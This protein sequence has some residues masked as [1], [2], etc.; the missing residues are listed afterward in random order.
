MVQYAL[1]EKG[2]HV[3]MGWEVEGLG[4]MG[5]KGWGL[6]EGR[7]LFNEPDVLEISLKAPL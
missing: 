5:L 2:A 4:A 6:K 1:V 3:Q 7:Y